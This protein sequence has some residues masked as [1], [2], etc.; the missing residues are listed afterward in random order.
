VAPRWDLGRAS[1]VGRG[2]RSDTGQ[3][4]NRAGGKVCAGGLRMG[5]EAAPQLF[6]GQ[7]GE[8]CKGVDRS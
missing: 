3:G 8:W 4:I 2:D 7:A 1:R 5:G 6:L